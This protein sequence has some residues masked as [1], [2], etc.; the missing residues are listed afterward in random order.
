MKQGALDFLEKP[1]D[2]DELLKKV[3]EAKARKM[4]LVQKRVEEKIAD[5]L[6]KKHW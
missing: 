6:H 1:A 4:V 2:F 3:K 5:I